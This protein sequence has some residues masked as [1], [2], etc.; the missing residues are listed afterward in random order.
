M[1]T[2]C[3]GQVLATGRCFQLLLLPEL[4]APQLGASKVQ[5]QVATWMQGR[6]SAD[7]CK[8]PDGCQG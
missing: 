2:A 4:Q 5:M 6:M 1:E 8:A 7:A 3:L